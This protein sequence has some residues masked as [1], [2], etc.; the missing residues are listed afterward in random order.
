MKLQGFNPN[1]ERATGSQM[2]R[3]AAQGSQALDPTILALSM[4]SGLFSWP[5]LP[6][7]ARAGH[8]SWA[9]VS[10]VL[11][12]EAWPATAVVWGLTPALPAPRPELG[13]GSI[14]RGQLRI[15]ALHSGHAASSQ[16]CASVCEDR[17]V[18]AARCHGRGAW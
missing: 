6:Q 9:S 17:P 12:P 1:T 10:E 15:L 13:S 7:T 4:C 3:E 8:R 5:F 18:A 2:R 16:A 14:T 11:L